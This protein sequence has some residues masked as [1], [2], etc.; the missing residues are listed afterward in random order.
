MTKVIGFEN[1][2]DFDGYRYIATNYR[3]DDNSGSYVTLADYETQ[4]AEIAKLRGLLSRWESHQKYVKDCF[5]V[6]AR[7]DSEALIRLKND[8]TEALK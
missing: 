5:D 7:W 6:Y 2:G 8:T 3:E 1:I 4:A